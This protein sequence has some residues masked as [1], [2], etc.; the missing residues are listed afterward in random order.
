[1][2]DGRGSERVSRTLLS[3]MGNSLHP[4]SLQHT[5]AP[6]DD[7]NVERRLPLIGAGRVVLRPALREGAVDQRGPVELDQVARNSQGGGGVEQ[8]GGVEDVLTHGAA[9]VHVAA[10]GEQ[11]RDHLRAAVCGDGDGVGGE[12]TARLAKQAPGGR[13]VALGRPPL[14]HTHVTQ[15]TSRLPYLTA[16]HAVPAESMSAACFAT[17]GADA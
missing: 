14:S 12:G 13:A 9:R 8:H 15:R 1:M 10:V 11:L 3:L 16:C 7:G 5:H 17:C 2:G 4:L 6:V